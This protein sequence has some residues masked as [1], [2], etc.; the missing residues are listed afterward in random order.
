M[1]VVGQ[2]QTINYIGKYYNMYV[3]T[4]ESRKNHLDHLKMGNSIIINGEAL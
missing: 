2:I 1:T 4:A 3:S